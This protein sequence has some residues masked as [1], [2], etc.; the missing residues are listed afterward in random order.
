MLALVITILVALIGIMQTNF[1]S[2]L[3][4]PRRKVVGSLFEH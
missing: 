3:L 1:Y 2:S 4:I